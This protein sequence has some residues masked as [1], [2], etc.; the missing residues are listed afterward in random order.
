MTS[1]W[2]GVFNRVCGKKKEIGDDMMEVA[3]NIMDI[4]NSL[5]SQ[6]V[7]DPLV[8]DTIVAEGEDDEDSETEPKNDNFDT[9]LDSITDYFA[10]TSHGGPELSEDAKELNLSSVWNEPD[11]SQTQ[12]TD[13]NVDLTVD[14]TIDIYSFA[15]VQQATSNKERES[16]QR[17]RTETDKL[18]SLTMSSLLHQGNED[19]PKIE[20]INCNGSWDSIV[21]FGRLFGPDGLDSEQQT[22]FEILAAIYVL[23]FH[24]DARENIVDVLEK[25]NYEKNK[26]KLEKLARTQL[27]YT[28]C[29]D[30][31]LRMFVTGPAGAGKCEHNQSWLFVSCAFVF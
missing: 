20:R 6:L 25:S 23:T 21:A 7:D 24:D 9:V 10:S 17:F 31:P 5:D 18:N 13:S 26:E 30:E 2:T 11:Y 15:P 16:Q 22:A 3:E 28:V 4:H 8:S 29:K 1:K 12:S 27:R 14:E 19:K